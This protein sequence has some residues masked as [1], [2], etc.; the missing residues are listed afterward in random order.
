MWYTV[1]QTS[2][3]LGVDL[4]LFFE[5]CCKL[6]D[7]G[8]ASALCRADAD[9]ATTPRSPDRMDAV[10]RFLQGVKGSAARGLQRAAAVG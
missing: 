6:L 9:S 7:E 3:R 1:V 2:L 10:R 8:V 5:Q 4:D